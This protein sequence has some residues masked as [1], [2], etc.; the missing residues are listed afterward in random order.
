L[1]NSNWVP[2]DGSWA[3]DP[4][5]KGTIPTPPGGGVFQVIQDGDFDAGQTFPG[6]GFDG[7]P[8]PFHVRIADIKDGTSNTVM[9][10]EGINP[11]SPSAWGGSMGEITH[12]DMGGALFTTYIT[13]NSSIPDN[14]DQTCPFTHGDT[15]Y[16]AP[17]QDNSQKLDSGADNPN[18]NANITIWN[19]YAGARSQHTGG[20][21]ACLADGSVRFVNNSI[22]MTT[23]HQVG[24][25][26]GN[27]VLGSDW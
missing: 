15:S 9:F 24:T 20:V 3:L 14:T 12:G 16:L 1:A 25:R 18:Y 7:N 19:A 10:S 23:W 21:N 2:N 27:E 17:C 26:A 5:F 8:K 11:T 6:V 13:P 22:S 4:T